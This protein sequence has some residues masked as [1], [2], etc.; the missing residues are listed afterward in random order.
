MNRSVMIVDA[1]PQSTKLASLVLEPEGWSVI[2]VGSAEAALAMLASVRPTLI[3]TELVL[4]TMPGLLFVATVKIDPETAHIPV[5]AV[6]T[7]NGPE[8]EYLA[9]YAGCVDYIRKPIEVE[10][11]ASRLLEATGEQP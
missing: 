1:D 11:F 7:L 10:N 9:F 5:V 3:A 2:V 6:T 8:T 4:P